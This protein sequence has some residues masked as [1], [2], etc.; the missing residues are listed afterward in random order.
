LLNSQ[1]APSA[2]TIRRNLARKLRLMEGENQ[3][4]RTGTDY[5]QIRQRT[6]S[7]PLLG[8]LTL[9]SFATP[10]SFRVT[11]PNSPLSSTETSPT[12]PILAP[13]LLADCNKIIDVLYCDQQ[14]EED[15]WIKGQ[16]KYSLVVSFFN[17]FKEVSKQDLY[18][19]Y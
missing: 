4:R 17:I 2:T 11:L 8:K 12:P 13:F 16:K 19:L 1:G 6:T 7:T 15:I 14:P 9:P 10:S 18:C 3:I 5:F